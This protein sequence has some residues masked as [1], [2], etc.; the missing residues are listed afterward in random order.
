MSRAFM[1]ETNLL[2]VKDYIKTDPLMI[3]LDTNIGSVSDQ[4]FFFDLN[5]LEQAVETD[6]RIWPNMMKMEMAG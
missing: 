5:Y 1:Q 6:L 2:E 4:K 3:N